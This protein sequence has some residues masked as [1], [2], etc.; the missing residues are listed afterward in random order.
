MDVAD[1]APGHL[2]LHGPVARE[3]REAALTLKDD[4]V[5]RDGGCGQKDADVER[6][7]DV[8]HQTR[9]V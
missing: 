9:L 4:S 1:P 6:S 8:V 7:E 5:L 2:P 3:D